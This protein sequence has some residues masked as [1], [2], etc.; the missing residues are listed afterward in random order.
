MSAMNVRNL[1]PVALPSVTIS[2]DTQEKGLMS[3]GNV[4]SHLEILPNS[5]DTGEVT[6]E[7][8][9]MSAVNVGNLLLPG[10]NFIII[11]EFTLEKNYVLGMYKFLF[12]VTTLEEIFEQP[13][14]F[15]LLYM[16]MHSGEISH[17]LHLYGKCV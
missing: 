5:V 7:K 12:C 15:K 1:L 4:E 2:E 10:L 17:K 6:L 3:V 13:S 8:G 16:N 11:R 9:L 14:E